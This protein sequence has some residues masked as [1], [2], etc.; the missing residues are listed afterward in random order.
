[1]VIHR[2][3]H[4]EY[5][6]DD[7]NAQ[8]KLMAQELKVHHDTMNAMLG[9]DFKPFSQRAGV[10]N[11]KELYDGNFNTNRQILEEENLPEVP[12]KHSVPG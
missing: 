5:Q 4:Y 2:S 7:Y 11:W 3:G 1:M 12:K 9:D 6:G 10:K 8:K